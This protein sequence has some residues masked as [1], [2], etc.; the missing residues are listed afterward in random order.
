[1]GKSET[2]FR[3]FKKRA[4]QYPKPGEM[5][6]RLIRRVIA[7]LR[8]RSVDLP[9]ASHILIAH[10]GGSDSTALAHL[11]LKYGR[12]LV[13]PENIGI[14]HVNH[15]WRGEASSQDEE[16]VRGFAEEFGVPFS[17]FRVEPPTSYEPGRSWEE[18]ARSLRKE[19]FRTEAAQKGAWIMTAHQMDDLA[20]T[21]L[22][23]IL[24]GA[25]ETH[26]GGIAF[27]HGPEIRPLLGVRKSEL[28]EYLKE[29]GRSFRSDA[30]NDEERFLRAKMRRRVFPE[31]EA[32]FPR[33]V[34]NLAQLGFDAQF[35][36]G[37]A[38]VSRALLG[39]SGLRRS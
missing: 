11:L 33:A 16:F 38:F 19:V 12:R 9:I 25:A 1:M 3:G 24:T 32:L 34:E 27:R 22:W 37:E 30:T 29:E 10:S 36:E 13:A 18:A 7:F 4:A 31:I 17:A 28:L 14:L 20:E 23:R 26:G 21:V 6:G 39:A 35:Q 15:G 5:G 2:Q 8:E